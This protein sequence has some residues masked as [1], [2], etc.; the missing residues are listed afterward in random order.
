[1]IVFHGSSVIV[2][3]PDVSYSK[4][5]LDFGDG[6]YLTSFREQAERWA[7]RKALRTENPA[8]VNVYEFQENYSQ[9]KFLLFEEDN[10][11]WIEFVCACRS[12]KD[13]YKQHDIIIGSVAN[14]KVY[15]AVDMYYKGIWD[16]QRTLDAL[17]YYE[18]N[19]QICIIN[20]NV[21]KENLTFLKSRTN[22]S[23]SDQNLLTT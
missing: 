7:K 4:H 5:N 23:I 13:I 15:M 9:F 12:G 14:D 16:M 1:M 6:F 2:E 17:S 18:M 3:S 22:A 8:I 10:E 20:Q 11:A 21:I 19:D